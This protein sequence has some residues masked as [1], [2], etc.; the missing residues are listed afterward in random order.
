VIRALKMNRATYW[1]ARADEHKR[2][3]AYCILAALR[4]IN[5]GRALDLTP[6]DLPAAEERYRYHSAEQDHCL[7]RAAAWRAR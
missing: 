1:Q 2:A 7:T 3:V 6:V 5:A 4:Y